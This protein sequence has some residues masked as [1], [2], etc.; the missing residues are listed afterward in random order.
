[1][2]NEVC[3]ILLFFCF[4]SCLLPLFSI[5][6]VTFKTTSRNLARAMCMKNLKL[7]LVIVLVCL[8]SSDATFLVSYS[9][10]HRLFPDFWHFWHNNVAPGCFPGGHLHYRLCCLRRAQLALLRPQVK[11]E[12]EWKRSRRGGTEVGESEDLVEFCMP[13]ETMARKQDF[14]FVTHLSSV[15]QEDSCCSSSP[16]CLV[17]PLTMWTWICLLNEESDLMPALKASSLVVENGCGT[18]TLSSVTLNHPFCL[19]H[20]VA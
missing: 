7:T 1:M 16:S 18:L 8:V 10:I 9:V 19:T 3:E 17:P 6:S 13:V 11:R 12:S 14:L 15:S 20:W 2:L 4:L 5:Q